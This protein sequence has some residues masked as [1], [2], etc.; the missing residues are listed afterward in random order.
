M[1]ITQYHDGCADQRTHFTGRLPA[2]LTL[3]TS[4]LIEVFHQGEKLSESM[5]RNGLVVGARSVGNHHALRQGEIHVLV[6]AC[7]EKLNELQTRGGSVGLRGEELVYGSNREVSH[8]SRCIS[9][10]ML[11]LGRKPGKT[12]SRDACFHH[13]TVS[14]AET[15]NRN[16][17]HA[18]AGRLCGLL[19]VRSRGGHV[20]RYWRGCRGSGHIFA[21]LRSRH[22]LYFRGNRGGKFLDTRKATLPISES[23]VTTLD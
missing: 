17:M 6:V 3:Q 5:L 12:S 1:A 15:V 20:R 4:I 19:S 16:D 13:L 10:Q 23:G 22:A 18:L 9:R 8:H 2:M 11:T 14:R 7:G 21:S